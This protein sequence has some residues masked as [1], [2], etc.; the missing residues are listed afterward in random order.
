MQIMYT[1]LIDNTVSVMDA[2][3][4][5]YELKT[6][7]NLC[8]LVNSLDDDLNLALDASRNNQ[9]FRNDGL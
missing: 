2:I 3:C 4:M 7:T 1:R 6:S 5:F 9:A 8:V